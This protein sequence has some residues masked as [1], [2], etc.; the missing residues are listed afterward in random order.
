MI[1]EGMKSLNTAEVLDKVREM[2][3]GIKEEMHGSKRPNHERIAAVWTWFLQSRSGL[4]IQ[5]SAS[6]VAAMM[7]LLKIARSTYGGHNID[8][9]LDMTGYSAI[10][11][12]LE[13]GSGDND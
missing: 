6:D 7:V 11:T 10:F 2:V 8:D 5:V 12:E 9:G 3:T 13:Y 1:A 4:N